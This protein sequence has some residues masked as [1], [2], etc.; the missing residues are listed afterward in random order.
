MK[1]V[2]TLIFVIAILVVGV[3][4]AMANPSIGTPTMTGEAEVI[5]DE[6]HP[7]SDEVAE[8]LDNGWSFG[9]TEVQPEMITNTD[10]A[11]AVKAVNSSETNATPEDTLRSLQALQPEDGLTAADLAGY[12]YV[13]QFTALVLTDGTEYYF[14]GEDDKMVIRVKLK[15]D[16]LV[17]ENP[18]NLGNYLVM[19]IDPN[20]GVVTTSPLL[21]DTF[22]SAEG[23][24]DVE[25]SS[26]GMFALIQ[27]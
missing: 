23:T 27:K 2:L 19:V 20:T 12:D 24:V 6:E 11:E 8:R 21:A 16:A 25:F 13:T 14:T 9:A 22:D 5:R 15:I 10:V 18:E 17:G 1:K 26:T 3:V 4:P 7:V